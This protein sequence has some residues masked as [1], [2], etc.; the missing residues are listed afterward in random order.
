MFE[1]RPLH[2]D[3]R[4]LHLRR[5]QLCLRLRHIGLRRGAAFEAIDR[6]LQGFLEGL[7]RV[8]EQPLL[9]VGAAQLEVIECQLCLN[10]E[11]GGFQVGGGC[12]RFLAGGGHTAADAAPQ[13]DLVGYVAGQK[14]VA[15]CDAPVSPT[16]TKGLVS[17]RA[18]RLRWLR[19]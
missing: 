9:R 3:V 2:G 7:D 12:L 8:V 1:L 18:Q 6:E 14:K 15:A 17:N 5:F 19:R 11:S 4:G 16:V 13:V 10:A